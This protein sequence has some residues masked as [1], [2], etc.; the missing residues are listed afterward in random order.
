MNLQP[1]GRRLRDLYHYL[2][3]KEALRRLI[4]VHAF[5][6]ACVWKSAIA[7]RAEILE[8]LRETRKSLD[9]GGVI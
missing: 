4:R 6:L 3:I 5:G 2:G 1:L 8:S 7:E 9:E